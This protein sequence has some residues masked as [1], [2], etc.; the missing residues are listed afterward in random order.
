MSNFDQEIDLSG[1]NC[2]MPVMKT[3]KA[4]KSMESGKILHVI[5]TDPGSMDDIPELVP[6]IGC[7]MIENKD[8]EGKFHF[9]IK[10]D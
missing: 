6:E 5:S 4:L 3:K 2:P 1:L 9:L 10:K 8:E 7:T